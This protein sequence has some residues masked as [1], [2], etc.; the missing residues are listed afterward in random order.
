MKV[1]GHEIEVD[2]LE[3]LEGF[4][5]YKPKKHVNEFQAC[6]PFRDERNPS[7]Y[8]NL[9]TG[10]W[11]DHGAESD[12]WKKGNLVS[13]LSFL[14]NITYEEAEDFLLE[15]YNVVISD[16]AGLELNIN[17]QM[18]T[19]A[20]KTFT[21]EELKPYLFREKKYLLSRGVSEDIQ[22]KFVVGYCKEQQAVAFFWLDAFSGKCVNVKFRSTR[23][24]HFFYARGGQPVRNHVFGLYQAI[25]DHCEKVYIVESE[26]DALFLWS[27]GI[28]AIALGGSYLSPEQKRK[29]LL[30]GINTFVIATDNDAAGERIRLSLVKELSGYVQLKQIT[31]PNYAKDVNEVLHH[32]LQNVINSETP[33]KLKMNLHMHV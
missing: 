1:K 15:K 23:G 20:P 19:K 9:E 14:H 10:L 7:F 16:V 3:E 27:N 31:L 25:Q 5:W 28:P 2:V 29:L 6:S 24:K 8:I 22:K 11:V 32:D 4:N 13:L 12:N 17:I 33:I 21:R 30:S 18:D 26:I